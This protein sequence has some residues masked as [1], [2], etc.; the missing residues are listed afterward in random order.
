MVSFAK[1]VNDWML[2]TIFGKSSILDAWMGSEYISDYQGVLSV[3]IIN[4]YCHFE[5][6]KNLSNPINISFKY[7]EH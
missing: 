5:S 4:W 6:S 7:L 2:L 3:I 1:K